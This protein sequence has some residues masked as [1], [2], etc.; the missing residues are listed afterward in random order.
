MRA[1]KRIAGITALLLL[2]SPAAQ[3][4]LILTEAGSGNVTLTLSSG[5]SHTGSTS[6]STLVVNRSDPEFGN[7]TTAAEGVYYTYSFAAPDVDNGAGKSNFDMQNTMGGLWSG[8]GDALNGAWQ[9]GPTTGTWNRGNRRQHVY[10]GGTPTSTFVSLPPS[11]DPTVPVNFSIHEPDAGDVLKVSVYMYAV[12]NT[13]LAVYENLTDGESF[14]Y[15]TTDP[16]LPTGNMY[17]SSINFRS[18]TGPLELS[19]TY[20]TLVGVPEPSSLLVFASM[21]VWIVLRRS[22]RRL[23]S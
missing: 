10:P 9:N 8:W 7:H 19:Y 22:R 6:F 23:N 18:D 12:D 16:N 13:V 17:F 5:S 4:S 1:I 15:L 11:A 20:G 21:G 14:Q 2:L 3:G